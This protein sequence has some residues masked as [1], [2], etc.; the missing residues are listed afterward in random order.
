MLSCY[1][2]QAMIEHRWRIAL[3][4]LLATYAVVVMYLGFAYAV[5]DFAIFYHS[6]R[7]ALH[8][9]DIYSRIHVEDYYIILHNMPKMHALLQLNLNPPFVI[10]LLLPLGLLDYGF[11]LIIWNTVGLILLLMSLRAVMH[12]LNWSFEAQVKAA[13]VLFLA[14]PVLANVM[15][16]QLGALISFLIIQVWLQARKE[17]EGLAGVF[18]GIAIAIKFFPGLLLF[19][20]LL[21]KRWHTFFTACAV[22]A[23]CMLVALWVF[24]FDSYLHYLRNIHGILWYSASW[25]ASLLG[26]IWRV[27]TDFKHFP[28]VTVPMF[29]SL[30]YYGLFAVSLVVL[31]R[32]THRQLQKDNTERQRDLLF[33]LFSVAMLILSPLGW[34]YYFPIMMLPLAIL[35][36]EQSE[37]L[38]SDWVVVAMAS[39]LLAFPSG[40]INALHMNAWTDRLGAGSFYFYSVCLLAVAIIL[41]ARQFQQSSKPNAPYARPFF[42]CVMMPSTVVVLFS[43]AQLV[44]PRFGRFFQVLGS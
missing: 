39:V 4:A 10:L 34:S 6:A 35:L 9:A 1:W 42:A 13:I 43:L 8:G 25:N 37:W 23:A 41:R 11:A 24:G 16:G 3:Y 17:R 5:T 19:W 14:Y 22:T 27:A 44:L 31:L 20:F 32:F 18:L 15:T 12:Q 29:V 28:D 38:Q 33:A 7:N 30:I 2:Y 21:Q 26:F 40:Y 36:R